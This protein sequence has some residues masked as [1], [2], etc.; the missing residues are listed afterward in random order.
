MVTANDIVQA[1][2][3]LVLT[4]GPKVVGAVVVL[5]IGLV[6]IGVVKRT[7]RRRMKRS[8]REPSLQHFLISL[9]GASL[10]VILLVSVAG[11]LG[12]AT[13]SF[14]AVLGAAG[15]A[16]GLA[17]QGSLANFAGGVLILML[18]PF[19][20]GEYIE[21]QGYSGTV[22]KIE[23][24]NTVL[25]TPDN[26]VLVLPNG[27]VSNNPIRNYTREKKRR[28]DITFGVGYGDNLQK[29][30]DIILTMA[31]KH[32]KIHKDPEPF[33]RVGELADSSVNFTVRLWTDTK[34]YW[35]V[36]FDMIE[37]VKSAFDKKRISIPYPQMD[38][39][40]HK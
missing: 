11:M 3:D 21:S 13:T 10:T 30:R 6:L 22:E 4:Y 28:V 40:M 12:I 27:Q 35:D 29:A 37:S 36:K 18:K 14:I 34:D 38:V 20:V 32:P 2:Q 17:L 33:C 16:I 1:G 8:K 26:Q 15:L 39:H 23:I 7:M 24:F 25:K 19:K 9:V 31:E 5:I